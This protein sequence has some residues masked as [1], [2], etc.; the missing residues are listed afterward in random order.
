MMIHAY[1][2]FDGHC[3]EAFAFYGRC[4]GATPEIM[5]VAGTPAAKQVP[6]EHHQSVMHAS[7]TVGDARLMGSD[8]MGRTHG[9]PAN[10][11]VNFGSHDQ[12]EVERVFAA[13]SEDGTVTMPLAPTFWSAAFGMLTDKFGV[14]WMVNVV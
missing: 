7:L 6:P 11:A 5:R 3:A 13:L 1:L 14:A 4:L 2:F 10:F 9:A 12:A 8:G